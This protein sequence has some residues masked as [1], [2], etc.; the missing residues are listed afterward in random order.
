MCQYATRLIDGGMTPDA[1]LSTTMNE[2]PCEAVVL[3]M[4]EETPDSVFV[5]RINYPMTVGIAEDGDI[6]FA[7]TRLAFPEDVRFTGI[8]LLPAMQTYEITR[9][10]VRIS[11]YPLTLGVK[12][13]GLTGERAE[14][15][16]PFFLAELAKDSGRP[17]Q[18]YEL[19]DCYASVWPQGELDQAEPMLYEMLER[20]A[21]EGRLGITPIAIEGISPNHIGTKFGVFEKA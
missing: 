21:A 1:A 10:G 7:T 11:P 4:R 17:K 5:S 13:A 12:V 14:A 19:L 18:G 16:Y 20:L 3:M 15:A 9:G 6:Y 2:L 8:G